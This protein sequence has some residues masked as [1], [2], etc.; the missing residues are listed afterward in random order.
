[1]TSSAEGL[2]VRAEI[3][4][5]SLYDLSFLSFLS[6]SL[7]CFLSPPHLAAFYIPS[8]LSRPLLGPLAL[9]SLVSYLSRELFKTTPTRSF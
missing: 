9:L 3:P 5:L 7:S 6:V 8:S 4:S 2:H 1:M